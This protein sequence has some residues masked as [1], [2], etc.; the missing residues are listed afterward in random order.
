[1]KNLNYFIL[2]I[3][4]LIATV[5]CVEDKVLEDTDPDNT[6]DAVVN[7]TVNS[8]DSPLTKI[9]FPSN[10]VPET[11]INV[12][13]VYASTETIEEA[14]IYFAVGDTPEYVKANKVSGEDDA[15][16]TQ[17][18]VTINLKE[19][20][21]DLG[22]SLSETSA[23]VSFYIRIATDTAEYYYSNDGSMYLDDTPGGGSTDESDD[24]KDNPALWNV[25]NV[26]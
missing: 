23:K 6:Y 22:L 10:P 11:D 4:T 18:G 17:T 24:F 2:F 25:Y 7:L 9:T 1:M 13:L 26:Q 21:T 15:S 3:I 8:T 14:R 20:S 16:F 19:V 12:V 5:S